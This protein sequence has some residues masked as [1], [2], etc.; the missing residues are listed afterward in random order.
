VISSSWATAMP[1]PTGREVRE[2]RAAAR[3]HPVCHVALQGTQVR[4]QRLGPVSNRHRVGDLQAVQRPASAVAGWRH[5]RR[6]RVRA[7]RPDL[8]Q[9]RIS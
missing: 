3:R 5:L 2:G 8:R 7:L 9:P 4:L 6:L 1:P